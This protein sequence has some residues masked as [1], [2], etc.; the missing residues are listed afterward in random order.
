MGAP[1]LRTRVEVGENSPT[2]GS[3]LD[4]SPV[5]RVE[6]DLVSD[7]YRPESLLG[8]GATAHVW[9]AMDL[10]VG[11]PV[12][13]KF[14]ARSE[15]HSVARFADEGRIMAKLASPFVARVLDVGNHQGVSFWVMEFLEGQTLR[16]RLLTEGRLSVETALRIL[17]QTAEGLS[18]AHRLGVVHRDIKPENI[19]LS[20]PRHATVAKV[21]DFGVAKVVGENATQSGY[22]LGTLNYASPEQL[23]DSSRADERADL[24]ALAVVAFECLTG[25]RPFQ[26]RSLPETMSAIT[27]GV[28]TVPNSVASALPE[29]FSTWFSK[30]VSPSI[31]HRFQTAAEFSRSLEA[32]LQV[33]EGSTGEAMT[34]DQS[35][36][37]QSSGPGGVPG[38]R[39][40]SWWRRGLLPVLS[41]LALG[42]ALGVVGVR[43]RAEPHGSTGIRSQTAPANEQ[44]TTGRPPPVTPPPSPSVGDTSP[45]KG[46]DAPED[47]DAG[48]LVS[49]PAQLGA[50][51][52]PSA[53][54]ARP[55]HPTPSLPELARSDDDPER[56][57]HPQEDDLW[58]RRR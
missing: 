41:L 55:L 14:L 30:A 3:V 24:W 17:T 9:K 16:E 36:P 38:R 26:G 39:S 13:I 7:R 25:V 2:I 54:S 34:L 44:A 50:P 33:P 1:S 51:P 19:F 29:G 57:I 47:L 48:V 45:S 23:A 21:L 42:A 11:A 35:A 40:Y 20:G 43:S 52:K 6:G 31:G 28:P 18:A 12:A 8:T 5:F 4:L 10:R 53:V 27:A 22:M 58:S 56:Q 49:D 15:R 32:A 46:G 37:L